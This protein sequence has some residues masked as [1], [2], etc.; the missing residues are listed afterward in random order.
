M[1]SRIAPRTAVRS[2]TMR[3]QGLRS[4][5]IPIPAGNRHAKSFTPV[6][7]LFFSTESRKVEPG[8]TGGCLEAP[9]FC[10]GTPQSARDGWPRASQSAAVAETCRKSLLGKLVKG[11][12]ERAGDNRFS[13]SNRQNFE[14]PAHLNANIAKQAP[15]G[16]DS[17]QR[18]P[19]SQGVRP[20]VCNA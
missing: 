4:L 17:G 9:H 15:P 7:P 1:K 2:S 18:P 12:L 3:S 8:R 20:R 16:V 19:L 5:V 14:S 6:I 13:G 11:A 10:V